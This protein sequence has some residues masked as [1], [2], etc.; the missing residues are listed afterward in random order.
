M[1][2]I[3]SAN[4]SIGAAVAALISSGSNANATAPDASKSS[5]S[6][7]PS[8]GINPATN[9]SLSDQAKAVLARAKSDQV[10]AAELQAFL[11]A[12]RIGSKGGADS[13]GNTSASTRTPSLGNFTGQDGTIY[14]V[15]VTPTEPGSAVV[16]AV[17]TVDPKISFSSQLQAGGFTISATGDASTGTYDVEI[18]GPNGF[19]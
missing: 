8:F 1:A 14:G 6:A 10:A 12:H 3:A 17:P 19:H 2:T 5:S 11:E 18:D 15:I 4:P 13:A 16:T 7:S 9:V